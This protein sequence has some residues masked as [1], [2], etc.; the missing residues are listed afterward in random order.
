KQP[1]IA[2]TSEQT[3][4][5]YLPILTP[6]SNSATDMI[7]LR[8]TQHSNQHSA[9]PLT[10][11]QFSPRPY[12]NIVPHQVTTQTPTLAR[13]HHVRDTTAGQ[14]QLVEIISI[15][16]HNNRTDPEPRVHTPEPQPKYLPEHSPRPTPVDTSSDFF[17][18]NE[19][20]NIDVIE[21][22]TTSPLYNETYEEPKYFPFD[23][24]TNPILSSSFNDS[25]SEVTT[26]V[27]NQQSH[28]SP[29]NSPLISPIATMTTRSQALEIPNIDPDHNPSKLSKSPLKNALAMLSTRRPSIFKSEKVD[30]TSSATSLTSTLS[31][32]SGS[33]VT[34]V[35]IVVLGIETRL[36]ATGKDVPVVLI[37]L[38]EGGKEKARVQKWYTDFVAF[39][40]KGGKI[41]I[42]WIYVRAL[43]VKA[44][45]LPEKSTFILTLKPAKMDQKRSLI[46]AY[47]QQVQ[48]VL[49]SNHREILDFFKMPETTSA[50]SLGAIHNLDEVSVD[51]SQSNFENVKK[52]SSEPESK[53]GML[54]K[55]VNN[56]GEVK[57]RWVV[58]RNGLVD[59]YDSKS[60]EHC[61]TIK[62]KY[63]TVNQTLSNQAL[64]NQEDKH[65]QFIITE[66]KKSAFHPQEI[67][68]FSEQQHLLQHYNLEEQLTESKVN[69]QH[70]F[71]IE[72]ER[73][74][75]LWI[76]AVADH[77][78]FVR[79]SYDP[80][81]AL[82]NNI[83]P[84][85]LQTIMMAPLQNGEAIEQQESP[86]FKMP[87]R[88]VQTTSA[89]DANLLPQLPTS[90]T[91]A[92][93]NQH[94]IKQLHLPPTITE[95]FDPSTKSYM[96][97]KSTR[98][99]AQDENERIMKQ[100]V[101]TFILPK[102]TNPGAS[103]G[104]TAAQ[105][106]KTNRMTSISTFN[107]GRKKLTV[108]DN[109]SASRAG[110]NSCIFGAPLE[111]AVSLSRIID[112]I[113]LPAVLY[114]C[115]EYL[116]ANNMA[117]EEGIYRLSGTSSAI[118]ALRD[119]FDTEY[120]V[121]LLGSGE[122]IDI[123]VIAGLLKLYLR[124]LPAPLLTRELQK[125]FAHVTEH[126]ERSN[127]VAELTAL[128]ARLPVVN[129]TAL[130]AVVGH[131]I[132]IVQKSDKNK[133]TVRNISIV[134]SPTLGVPSGVFVLMMADFIT[135]FPWD[136]RESD[137]SSSTVSQPP[138][139]EKSL[140]IPITGAGELEKVDGYPTRDELNAT[141]V[142]TALT[143]VSGLTT[144][145]M[146]H[147]INHG[148][149]TSP[150]S[151]LWGFT[152]ASTSVG[153]EAVD[154]K[155]IKQIPHKSSQKRMSG[156]LKQTQNQTALSD[157]WFPQ[158]QDD[159]NSFL[160]GPMFGLDN[161]SKKSLIVS[162]SNVRDVKAVSDSDSDLV[163]NYLDEVMGSSSAGSPPQ[164]LL[165]PRTGVRKGVRATGDL[166]SR[167]R[168]E[169]LRRED[170]VE[171]DGSES[172]GRHADVEDALEEDEDGDLWR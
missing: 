114:R 6:L 13:T 66:Y 162:D 56:L 108:S 135:V 111:I 83:T 14:M 116:E 69:N 34:G 3:S 130:R 58:L 109:S 140:P 139:N 126:E 41:Y 35:R 134:F 39:D 44:S 72:D 142:D 141:K 75:D 12:E 104:S 100:I 62:L 98:S 42:F 128:V 86:Y 53:T 76:L 22:L 48:A 79:Q 88:K 38:E 112:T 28:N 46:E 4:K 170:E 157:D 47:L 105:D 137:L 31:F 163:G 7:A 148:P 131:I 161:G 144:P 94:E 150:G 156:V 96:S 147:M 54:G 123:H 107:W 81:K 165:S 1:S 118:A 10:P 63:C 91:D 117:D 24:Q 169:A 89:A 145:A 5:E 136:F 36:N 151:Q 85:N 168:W 103:V 45:K 166:A 101:P 171:R 146:G 113:P 49:G 70:V 125:K 154:E 21:D 160:S 32:E 152:S 158:I 19:N 149:Q 30:D 122:Y 9:R 26:D 51:T 167:T 132:R 55:R 40:A 172:D 159:V 67:G 127:R 64:P 68:Q 124:E 20:D 143:K 15:G 25:K 115:I 71:I 61:G 57:L 60:R 59:Y 95:T 84:P 17:T 43:Q 106:K 155:L 27:H 92:N 80:S 73:Q 102:S 120:D 90:D 8:S 164:T 99:N 138:P 93:Q 87:K 16:P 110:S 74:R 77:I 52:Q 37:C 18:F 129:Y 121:D 82:Y 133:M 33:A 78:R 65:S 119:R 153:L 2:T 97:L 50:T 29:S 23:Q 11:D